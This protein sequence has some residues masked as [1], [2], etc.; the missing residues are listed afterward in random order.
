[1]PDEL[2]TA[3]KLIETA[4]D[5]AL[6]ILRKMPPYKYKSGESRALYG[7]L[8]IQALDS[9]C[10]PLKPD[11]LLDFSIA[12]YQSHPHANCLG[13]AYFYKGRAYKYYYQYEPAIEFYLKALDEAK[14]TKDNNMN[15]KINYDLGEIY[16]TQ[17]DYALARQKLTTA[18]SYLVKANSKRLAFYSLM[19]IGRT[20]HLAHDYKSAQAYYR[21]ILH[22]AN[23]SI[24]RGTLLQEIALNFYDDKMLDSAL[25]YLREV[26]NYPYITNNRAIRYSILADLYFDI[27]QIDSSNYYAL[28]AFRFEPD[29]RTQKKCYRIL[30]NAASIKG[31]MPDLKKYMARYQDC[32]DSIRKIDIQTK[33]SVL[34]T[35]HD[36]KKEM[37]K[38]NQKFWYV[39]IILLL[40][41]AIF[42]LAYMAKHRKSKL[43]KQLSEEKRLQLRADLRMEAVMKRQEVL[44]RKIQEKRVEYDNVWKKGGSE[45]R[46]NMTL[47]MYEELLHFDDISLFQKEMDTELNHLVTKLQTR[48][49][50]LTDKEI[51]WCCLHLLDVDPADMMVLFNYKVDSLKR[52]KQRLVNKTRLG[53]VNEIDNFLNAILCE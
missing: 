3:E 29:I 32:S 34:E 44:Q 28:N 46:K 24:Q 49:P 14:S 8:M 39:C 27:N 48:Y 21:Q 18:Y 33:G 1:M 4:P 37:A 16:S 13:T 22:R 9:K 41:I 50:T 42:I 25:I 35:M 7:L 52:M 19:H 40:A 20:F 45:E 11:S 2:T 23:D 17:A 30:V 12:Y 31:N 47:K 36:A 43:E 53:G 15:G 26:V 38:S 6:H 5:S 10:L 51:H